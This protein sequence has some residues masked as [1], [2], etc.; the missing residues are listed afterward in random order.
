MRPS[1]AL[2]LTLVALLPACQ[3]RLA[4]DVRVEDTGAGTFEVAVGLD[5][6]LTELLDDAGVDL[7]AGLQEIRERRPSWTIETAEEDGDGGMVVRLR[8]DFS[9]PEELSRLVAELHE[10]LDEED[11]RILDGVRLVAQDGGG[12][13]FTAEAGFIPPSSPGARGEGLAFDEEDLDRLLSERG[14][15]FVRYDLRVTLPGEIVEHNADEVDGT[16]LVW[17]APIGEFEQVRA[18]SEPA[19]DTAFEEIATVGA[20]AAILA[21]ATT[22]LV[23][24]RRR[25][26]HLV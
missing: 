11:P 19:D 18:V 24:R 3:L 10:G 6:E 4:A 8:A 1:L 2:L 25:A 5:R 12:F 15:E 23:R 7:L 21:A 20:L 16:S 26:A 22:V 9:D 17:R 13:A 14:D